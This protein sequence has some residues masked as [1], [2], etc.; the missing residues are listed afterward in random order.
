MSPAAEL[1]EHYTRFRV[2]DRLLLTGHSHQAW[3]DV[4]RDGVIEAYD[5]AALAVE[6][7]WARAEVRAERLRAGV[8]MLLDDPVA[9]VALGA[10]A[11]ELLVR[12]L[13]ALPLR[14]RPRVV[15]T[16]G[17][18]DSARRQLDRLA[19]AGI[20][21]VRVP[22]APL[23]TLAE[24][25]AALVDTRTAAVVVSSVL[26]ETSR[27]VPGL[28]AVAEACERTGAELLVDAYHQLGVVPWSVGAAGLAEAWVVGGGYKYLQL[29][30]GNCFLRVPPHARGAEPVVTGWFA[31]GG[32]RFAG[33]TYDPTSHYRAA[34]VLNF[35]VEQDLTPPRLREISLH[36][37][38]LLAREFDALGLPDELVTRDR[39]TPAEAFGGFLALA[40]PQ[41][42]RL[43]DGLAERGVHADHRGQHLRLGP[44][45]YL[46]DEQLT[47]AM[48]LLGEAAASVR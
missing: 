31:H 17:E 46:T 7:K 24:R 8:R 33:S 20:E 27:I 10:S 40:S 47:E 13:S 25:V 28:A 30:E 21:L 14:S 34:R 44:A 36:Q 39:D 42:A 22:T 15:T 11:H 32:D 1:A 4:A 5:D 38:G 16:D 23:G 35:F 29:G 12:F 9:E 48:G 18:F 26:F 2:A 6:G 45:P 19:D 43:R 3:P 41:A 37:R